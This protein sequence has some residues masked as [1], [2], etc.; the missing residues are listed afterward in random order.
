MDFF[1]EVEQRLRLQK[2]LI[3]VGLV[4]ILENWQFTQH[5]ND[6]LK[7]IKVKI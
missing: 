7:L 1:A 5:K 6:C 3:V 2:N 4:A